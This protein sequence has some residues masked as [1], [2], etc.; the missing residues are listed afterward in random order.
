MRQFADFTEVELAWARTFHENFPYVIEFPENPDQL[1]NLINSP[2]YKM[3]TNVFIA[4][5]KAVAEYQ[6]KR[7]GQER[8]VR[9][10]LGVSNRNSGKISER[11]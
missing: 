5:H 6:D 9:L 11:F 10:I 1:V 2:R 3:K 4:G 8:K 7:F